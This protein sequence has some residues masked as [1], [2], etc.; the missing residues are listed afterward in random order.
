ML[1]QMIYIARPGARGGC[2]RRWS[3]RAQRSCYAR[4]WSGRGGPTCMCRRMRTTAV[5]GARATG[6]TAATREQVRQERACRWVGAARMCCGP[7]LGK[8]GGR[9]MVHASLLLAACIQ[10]SASFVSFPAACRGSASDAPDASLFLFFYKNIFGI[11]K[12]WFWCFMVSYWK[13]EFSYEWS[14]ALLC[15]LSTFQEKQYSDLQRTLHYL[16]NHVSTFSL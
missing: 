2:R 13:W 14:H 6:T 7:R 12:L 10:E 15:L 1:Q 11:I 4:E 3:S 8:V 16:F 5:G 9:G